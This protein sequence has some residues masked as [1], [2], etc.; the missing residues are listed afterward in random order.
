MER[1]L[2]IEQRGDYNFISDF[3]MCIICVIFW[4]L[5]IK[6]STSSLLVKK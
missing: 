4:Y 1:D 3:F 6:E 5:M 2:S